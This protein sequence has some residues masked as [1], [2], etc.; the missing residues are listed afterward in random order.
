MQEDTKSRRLES[1]FSS[2]FAL[3]RNERCERTFFL[4][5][6]S[7]K[8]ERKSRN[9]AKN[10]NQSKNSDE[11]FVF[12]FALHSVHYSG[13]ENN[14]EK[15]DKNIKYKNKNAHAAKNFERRAAFCIIFRNF[16]QFHQRK[17]Q[18]SKRNQK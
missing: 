16:A 8:S 7:V 9:R 15:K 4:K 13:G 5:M 1:R 17:N 11:N 12:H 2:F 18:R 6:I 10:H 3:I 14:R